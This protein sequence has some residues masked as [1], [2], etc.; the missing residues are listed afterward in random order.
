MGFE[1]DRK[2]ESERRNKRVSPNEEALIIS[3]FMFAAL[4]QTI[5][6]FTYYIIQATEPIFI[7]IYIYRERERESE[8]VVA[9]DP[10][11]IYMYMYICVYIFICLYIYSLT[12]WC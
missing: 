10:T 7:Y 5:C 12:Y 6:T 9:T 3:W 11:Y 2:A 1:P 4:F 8:T